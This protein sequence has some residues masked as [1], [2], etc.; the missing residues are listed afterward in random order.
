MYITSL[1]WIFTTL[2]TL[3]YGDYYGWTE[4]E[5]IFTMIIE[6]IGIFVFAY[7]MGNINTLI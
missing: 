3:G 1:Y 6:I 5:M 7:I 4:M 2:S